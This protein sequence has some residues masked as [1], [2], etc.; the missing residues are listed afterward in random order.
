MAIAHAITA[1]ER[2]IP[3]LR[4]IALKQQTGCLSIEHMTAAGSEKGEVF[5]VRGDTI[6]GKC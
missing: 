5:F 6:L 2:L 4:S 1:T 3:I